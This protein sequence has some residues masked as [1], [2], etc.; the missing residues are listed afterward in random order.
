MA[1]VQNI[2]HGKWEHDAGL[3]RYRCPRNIY[4]FGPPL[5]LFSVQKD[6]TPGR[7][8]HQAVFHRFT[9]CV[10]DRARN[11]DGNHARISFG[12]TRAII[13]QVRQLFS[14]L[15]LLYMRAERIL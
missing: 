4:F 15:S 7:N 8:I 10:R 5:R 12:A 3:G 13:P 6:P 1:K 11:H 2:L 14:I 9:R